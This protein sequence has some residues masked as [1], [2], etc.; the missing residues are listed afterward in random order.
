V[1][2]GGQDH[3]YLETHASLALPEEG[4]SMR[5]LSST[6]HPTEAQKMAARV[7][8]IGAHQ[9]VC[10]VP[11]MGG[12]FGGK[13]SQSTA[14]ACLAALGGYRTGRP[15]KVWLPRHED[16]ATT[17]GRH[18]FQS[19]YR[20]GFAADGRLLALD[21]TLYADAGWTT[22]LSLAIVD[23]AL[24][25]LDNACFVEHARFEGHACHTDKPTS[26]A[27][28]GF[29]GPQGMIVLAHAIRQGAV[30]LGLPPEQVHRA[31]YYGPA[32]RDRTPYGQQ[33]P[34]PRIAAMHD[35]LVVQADLAGRRAQ[36]AAWN[37]S[38]PWRKRGI[39]LQPLK[40]GISFTAG[41]L[42]QA[43]ALVLVYADG[44]VQVN[45]GG[46]EM[47]QGLHTKMLAV[48]CDT[49]GV[50]A[51]SV[52]V[53]P[54]ST[55]KVPNTSAT[56]ASSGSDLNG[57]ALRL[58]CEEVRGRMAPV[59][60]ELLSCAEAELR[61]QDGAV[62]G[63]EGRSVPFAQ[64]AAS[65]WVRRISLSSTGYYATPG[66]QYDRER[67]QGTPFFY[68]AYGVAIVEVEVLGLTGEH[69]VRRVDILHDVGDSLVP[70][71][72]VG[73][74]EGAFVQGLGWLTGEEVLV[75]PDGA[76]LT[77]GPSTYKIPSVGD[78]PLDLRVTLLEHQP[79]EGTIGGSKAVGEP[80]LMLAIA[81]LG[82]L[83]EAIGAFGEGP[84]DLAVPATGEAILRAV[85]TARRR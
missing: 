31:S 9:V 37:A 49:L 19:H 29:G 28:R 74:V 8:G 81:V 21:A 66:I 13:E 24:F 43:G 84:V 82:A 3:F 26:T 78:V 16:M 54:T 40:F 70:D 12:G 62:H 47:G 73:Q 77:V 53:M 42:N 11:R 32:P 64:V 41:L 61:W 68:F 63:P 4:G 46:T 34:S 80:P 44:T 59:A 20:A 23:R 38:S 27:F 83:E 39:A 45:H 75:R 60:A 52:R 18:P 85:E 6:Q 48:A 56:A 7:L 25:H 35:R 72:D 69:R 65:C 17:G 76:V 67:G 58:A 71:I 10:E 50:P 5:L 1:H 79:Q 55:E 51:T 15:C 14:I 2:S 30:A 57:Q 33:V 22:D 36:I